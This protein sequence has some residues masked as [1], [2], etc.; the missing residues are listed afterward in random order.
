M[1]IPARQHAEAN[2]LR[3]FAITAGIVGGIA[4]AIFVI[5]LLTGAADSLRATLP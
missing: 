3:L 2:L 4:L 1:S 5:G